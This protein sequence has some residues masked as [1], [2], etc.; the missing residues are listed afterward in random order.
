MQGAKV[1]GLKFGNIESATEE[2]DTDHSFI[3]QSGEQDITLSTN[4][5]PSRNS[6]NTDRN[7]RFSDFVLGS[8]QAEQP[9][10]EDELTEIANVSSFSTLS[11]TMPKQH[12]SISSAPRT[13]RT[14]RSA[15]ACDANE[16]PRENLI[17]SS[18]E[19]RNAMDSHV[20]KLPW[21]PKSTNMTLEAAESAVPPLLYN[22]L[23]ATCE[24]LDHDELVNGMALCRL[25]PAV[26]SKVLFI[27]QDIL[28]LRRKGKIATPKSMAL[29][30]T[31][32]HMTGSSDLITI[33]SSLGH[34]MSYDT[35]CRAETAIA[36]DKLQNPVIVPDGFTIGKLIILVFDNIDFAEETLS[37]AG[38]THQVNGIMFQK[39]GENKGP[40][41]SMI[42]STPIS[43]RNRSINPPAQLLEPYILGKRT[44]M[45]VP[46]ASDQPETNPEVQQ[47]YRLQEF[48]YIVAKTETK[49]LLPAWTGYQKQMTKSALSQS[50]LHYLQNIEAPPNDMSTIS[51]VLK[52]SIE[53]AHTFQLPAVVVVFD[54]ALYSKAQ[55]IRW[56]DTLYQEKLVLR[57]G[58]FHTCMAFMGAIGKMFKLSGLEDVIIEAGVIAQGSIAGV[59]SGHNYNR[60]IRA[61]KLM[62]EALSILL[63]QKFVASM[64]E[65]TLDAYKHVVESILLCDDRDFCDPQMVDLQDQYIHYITTESA[66]SPMFA[67][68]S[69]YVTMV[70]I[71]LMF[72]RATR[73]SNWSAHVLTF[74][75][76]L[77]FF[78][79]LDRQNYARC[80]FISV[81][82]KM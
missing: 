28:C 62:Y 6:R 19:L 49:D 53:K 65:S 81:P 56:K 26:H 4:T 45:P 66:K 72:I 1:T 52:L 27:T 29:G 35:V 37:G 46:D 16:I 10:T 43:K 47:D 78:F 42:H 64:N 20:F 22:F 34:C 54:Q 7:S 55:Q 40:S 18:L 23:A 2:S 21:P 13:R 48:K 79:S 74:R 39:G 36:A 68:W 50:R 33:V 38:T 71:L 77:P 69:S 14:P 8:D 67:F 63:L 11:E 59:I 30:I 32:K 15:V 31:L 5:E 41:I 80:V 73:E 61:H 60:A 58:E 75:L 82:N 51:H 57:L 25:P 44:G 76:M 3:N 9:L 12:P 24:L 17:Y 70:E